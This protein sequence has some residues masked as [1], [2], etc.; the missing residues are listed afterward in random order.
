MYMFLIVSLAFAVAD[1]IYYQSL[2]GRLVP[3][4][5]KASV[6]AAVSSAFR[7]QVLTVVRT[8]FLSLATIDDMLAAPETPFSLVN[9]GV[10]R[11]SL[12]AVILST[13][14]LAAVPE[15]EAHNTTYPGVRSSNFRLE[16]TAD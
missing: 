6:A 2:Q 12:L 14:T 7:E 3:F 9:R 13:D 16:D 8:R 4:A 1:H 5:A 10:S 15:L 11:T